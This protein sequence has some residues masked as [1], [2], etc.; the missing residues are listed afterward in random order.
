[1]NFRCC[2]YA[3]DQKGAAAAEFTLVIALLIIPILNVLDLGLYTWQRV[4][5]DNAAQMGAQAVRTTCSYAYQPATIYCPTLNSVVQTAVQSTSL[6]TGVTYSTAEHYYCMVSGSL[7]N[8]AD[9]PA[10]PPT[11]C[12]QKD[13]NGNAIGGLSNERPGDYIQ[14]TANYT[15]TPIFP[16]VSIAS[17]LATPITRTAWMRL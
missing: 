7:V 13:S 9:P 3:V 17:Q 8:V 5:V 14:I 10:T 1:M 12:S 2:R 16:A 15:Y 11:D 4:Q 6:G